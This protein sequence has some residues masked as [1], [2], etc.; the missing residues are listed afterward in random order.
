MELSLFGKVLAI[1]AMVATFVGLIV[2]RTL[3]E[4]RSARAGK[5]AGRAQP[6]AGSRPQAP[7]PR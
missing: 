4:R 3:D 1:L 5:R 6:R 2:Y 7:L